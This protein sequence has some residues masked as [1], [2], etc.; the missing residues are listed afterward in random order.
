MKKKIAALSFIL[1]LSF[2]AAV[3][4]HVHAEEREKTEKTILFKESISEQEIDI[5]IKKNNLEVRYDVP[6]INLLSVK[7]ISGKQSDVLEESPIIEE[8]YSSSIVKSATDTESLQNE[9]EDLVWNTQWDMQKVTGNKKSFKMQKADKSTIIA[10]VDSGITSNHPDLVGSLVKGSKNMVPKNGYN[11][12]E[13]YETGNIKD[14]ED[15]MGHGTGVAGQ[16]TANGVMKGAAPGIG[17]RGYRVFGLKSAKTEWILKAIIEASKDDADI[18]NLSLGEYMLISGKYSNGQNDRSEY[19]AY[20]RAIKYAY[21]KGSIVVAAVGNDGVD[22]TNRNEIGN[23]YKDLL[24][25]DSIYGNPK[26]VD[27]PASIS[28]VVSVGSTGPTG[29]R[30]IFSNYGKDFID[31]YAPGGDFR[32][33][34]TYGQEE[35]I[36]GGWFEKEFVLT[37]SID[38]TYYYDAGVSYAAPKVSAALGLVIS[39]YKWE[40]RPYKTLHHLKKH[41]K[42]LNIPKLLAK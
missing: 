39:K 19:K 37:T 2:G 27:M 35:W 21:K 9:Y 22:V 28:E 3:T 10:I 23:L 15:K 34:N 8:V 41:G 40:D 17:I 29:E 4:V 38:G 14:F 42:E 13:P 25:D 12:T 30:S 16:I 1:T 5:F 18:I 6:E 20:K 31:V 32:Y 36:N 7:S 26:V 24:V 33:L 11:G